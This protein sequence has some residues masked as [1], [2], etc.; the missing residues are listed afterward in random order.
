MISVFLYDQEGTHFA[1]FSM[2]VLPRK[3]DT[4]EIGFPNQ[5]TVKYFTVW[6]VVHKMVQMPAYETK[7]VEGV[8]VQCKVD[9][10]WRWEHRLHGYLY[11]PKTEVPDVPGTGIGV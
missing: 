5:Q 11:D 7:Y 2:D 6:R 8:P 9:I 1:S 4:M 3:D 10:P